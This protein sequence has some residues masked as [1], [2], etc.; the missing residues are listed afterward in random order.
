MYKLQFFAVLPVSSRLLIMSIDTT[1]KIFL[2]FKM[3]AVRHLRFLKVRNFN[4]WSGSEFQYACVIM[5]NALPI[6]QTVADT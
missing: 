2:F 3:A 4:C 1:F 6:G 5:P